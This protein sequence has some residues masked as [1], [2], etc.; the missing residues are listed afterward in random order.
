L[1]NGVKRIEIDAK[2]TEGLFKIISGLL[3]DLAS[4]IFAETLTNIFPMGQT[5]STFLLK[6]R[7]VTPPYHLWDKLVFNYGRFVRKR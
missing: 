5:V 3:V 7:S 6:R 4:E 1:K 2:C